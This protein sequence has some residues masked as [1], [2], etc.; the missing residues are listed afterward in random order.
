MGVKLKNWIV[1]LDKNGNYQ[2]IENTHDGIEV[3]GEIVGE[4]LEKRKED[5]INYLIYIR[6][7]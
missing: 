6:K 5:A 7:P 2:A 1:Y 4:P 3:D